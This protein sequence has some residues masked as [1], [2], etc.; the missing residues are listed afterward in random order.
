MDNS[1]Q[2]V[3]FAGHGD[4]DGILVEGNKGRAIPVPVDAL[5]DLFGLC[6]EH[7]ECVI[8]NAC[9]SEIQATAIAEHIPYVIGMSAGI[10]DRAAIEFAVGFY[11]ALG[12]GKPIEVAFQ[13]AQN[14]V[15][16]AGVPEDRTPVLIRRDD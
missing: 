8:L 12:A 15:A 7:V 2:I 6:Q 11:D 10:S 16:L 9:H 3:H 14:A 4:D 13:F 5:A 1:P